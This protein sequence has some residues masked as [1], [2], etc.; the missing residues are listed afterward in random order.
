VL[1]AL[2]SSGA[3][4]ERP[5]PGQKALISGISAAQWEQIIR[6]GHRDNT[7]LCAGRQIASI[8]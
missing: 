2:N 3:L 1:A 6:L 5:H 8:A 7:G 4:T